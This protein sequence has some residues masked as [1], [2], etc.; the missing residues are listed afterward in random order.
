MALEEQQSF[1]D[2]SQ[3]AGTFY[4]SLTDVASVLELWGQL[5]YVADS[6][7]IDGELVREYIGDDGPVKVIM[8]PSFIIVFDNEPDETLVIHHIQRTSFLRPR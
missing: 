8:G 6:G 1:A 2:F 7:E 4:E 3:A 5:A